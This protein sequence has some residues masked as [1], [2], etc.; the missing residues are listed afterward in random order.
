MGRDRRIFNS[1]GG[2]VQAIFILANGI[3]S[4]DT[5]NRVFA[6][7]DPAALQQHFIR[8]VQ[9]YAGSII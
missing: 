6:L 8:W 1:K 3:P 2:M 4:H 7:L 9:S 5:F